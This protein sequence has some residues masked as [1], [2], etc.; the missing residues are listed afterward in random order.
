MLVVTPAPILY[1]FVNGY[2][3]S[4]RG[5]T[6]HEFLIRRSSHALLVWGL[7]C[8][9]HLVALNH[10]TSMA[11]SSLVNS[12][13][14]RA[15]SHCQLQQHARSILPKTVGSRAAQFH[16]FWIRLQPPPPSLTWGTRCRTGFQFVFPWF[17]YPNL[18]PWN[19]LRPCCD[20]P[21]GRKK[22]SS[23]GW[24]RCEVWCGI[25]TVTAPFPRQKFLANIEM[26][27]NCSLRGEA[28][29]GFLCSRN[30]SDIAAKP[31][32]SCSL[33]R[34]CAQRFL[35]AVK[36]IRI[37]YRRHMHWGS[38]PDLCSSSVPMNWLHTCTMSLL[39]NSLFYGLVG[40]APDLS[41]L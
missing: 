5:S 12:P 30:V 28:T 11:T 1:R 24:R 35:I 6:S 7:G 26:W 31:L 40:R 20:I 2:S 17:L 4:G 38:I 22:D 25:P 37:Y 3:A 10:H 8:L 36:Q 18:I 23:R 15:V 27:V 19:Y 39:A 14:I 29:D 41:R 33:Y 34:G 13:V 21:N 9:L 32:L 16:L